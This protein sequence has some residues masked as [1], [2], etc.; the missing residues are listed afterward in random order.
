MKPCQEDEEEGEAGRNENPSAV[1][2]ASVA[3]H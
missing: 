3:H 1:P 2:L